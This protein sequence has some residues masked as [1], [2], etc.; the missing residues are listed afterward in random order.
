MA[1]AYWK[2]VAENIAKGLGPKT[3]SRLGAG[4]R[5]L[6]RTGAL[7]GAGF[8]A[9]EL[10]KSYKD[11]IENEPAY[12][13]MTVLQQELEKWGSAISCIGRQPYEDKAYG[14]FEEG[15][16]V[17]ALYPKK[18]SADD[19]A[20]P[21]DPGEAVELIERAVGYIAETENLF[22]DDEFE[23]KR[24]DL[25]A[26]LKLLGQN[27][28]KAGNYASIQKELAQIASEIKPIESAYSA[29][30]YDCSREIQNNQ[31]SNVAWAAVSMVTLG[32]VKKPKE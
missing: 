4:G 28:G 19:P 10:L 18:L 8:M 3:V 1:A 23:G 26:R 13:E 25:V 21:A 9:Y 24:S 32:L 14:S 27:I 5:V 30:I 12:Q 20:K 6:A 31:G 29:R 11:N 7:V 17:N 15:G 16:A 2:M 22:E